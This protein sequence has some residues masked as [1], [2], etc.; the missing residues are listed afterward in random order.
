MIGI[1]VSDRSNLPERLKALS[2]RTEMEYAELLEKWVSAE[3]AQIDTGS[4]QFSLFPEEET[5]SEQLNQNR[6]EFNHSKISLTDFGEIQEKIVKL[7][8]RCEEIE[9]KIQFNGEL[10]P[11]AVPTSPAPDIDGRLGAMEKM[12]AD[13]TAKL[14]AS[15]AT[16]VRPIERMA[17]RPKTSEGTKPR[18]SVPKTTIERELKDYEIRII[19][20]SKITNE[21]GKKLSTR[22]IAE[23][24]EA[25]GVLS[26]KGLSKW[27][28]GNVSDYQKKLRERG[29]ME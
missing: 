13:L 7:E 12:I 15:N 16:P 6:E 24:L 3:E 5:K 28:S 4:K 17:T 1:K 9:S 18:K 25:E 27:S 29:L 10:N 19:E 2:K 8:S 20:L 26:E 14:E 21:A 23:R 11:T 22:A